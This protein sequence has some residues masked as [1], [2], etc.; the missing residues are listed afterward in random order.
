MANLILTSTNWQSRIRSK[1]GVDEAYLPDS[2]IEQPDVIAVAETNIIEQI[3]NYSSL[4][5]SNRILLEAAV[6]CECASILCPSMSARIPQREAG[7]NYSHDISV[8]WNRK[9][10][11]IDNEKDV[12]ISRILGLASTYV[13]HFGLSW[14]AT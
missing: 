4:T 7:P 14:E 11:D 10:L 1:L 3:S 6:V 5:G 8:N 13:P 2:E 9:K 12:Y